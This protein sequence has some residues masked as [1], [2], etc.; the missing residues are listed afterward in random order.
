MP[1]QHFEPSFIFI[2]RQLI[3]ISPQ[4]LIWGCA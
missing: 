4:Q 2:S 3:F 1:K